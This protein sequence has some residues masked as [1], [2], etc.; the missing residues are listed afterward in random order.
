MFAHTGDNHVKGV[1]AYVD[2]GY[3][4]RGIG[5]LVAHR[6]CVKDTCVS[7]HHMRRILMIA[8][9]IVVGFILLSPFFMGLVRR[10]TGRSPKE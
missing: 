3:P 4:V 10:L 5:S 9:I 1:R 7:Y 8:A 6:S 2:R